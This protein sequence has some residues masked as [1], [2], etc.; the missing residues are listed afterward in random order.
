VEFY[1][2]RISLF[3]F[4]PITRRSKGCLVSLF[5]GDLFQLAEAIHCQ[6][7]GKQVTEAGQ[8]NV[9][10][11]RDTKPGDKQSFEIV[12][13]DCDR[14]RDREEHTSWMKLHEFIETLARSVGMK[15][16]REHN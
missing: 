14:M 10:L 3:V 11:S 16:E 1:S 7:C 13:L 8:A 12:C 2:K 5:S 4:W 6:Q 15:A 9:I